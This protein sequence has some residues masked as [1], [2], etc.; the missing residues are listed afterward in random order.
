MN[1][2]NTGPNHW[3][4]AGDPLPEI[5]AGTLPQTPKEWLIRTNLVLG[6]ILNGL[7]AAQDSLNIEALTF[8]DMDV[9]YL[10]IDGN[11]VGRLENAGYYPDT[12]GR[13]RRPRLAGA[14]FSFHRHE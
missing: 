8:D 7:D 9:R 11:E 1:L 6:D 2:Q 13:G 12:G 5:K 3:S 14:V 10:S 4:L